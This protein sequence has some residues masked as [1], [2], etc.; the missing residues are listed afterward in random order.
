MEQIFAAEMPFDASW[1][2]RIAQGIDDPNFNHQLDAI[3]GWLKTQYNEQTLLPSG[4]PILDHAKGL[5][6]I[7]SVLELDPMTRLAGLMFAHRTPDLPQSLKTHSAFSQNNALPLI[8][9]RVAAYQR[10]VKLGVTARQAG[11]A[12]RGKASKPNTGNLHQ[13]P[14]QTDLLRRML[15]AMASDLSVVLMRLA[16]RLQTMRWYAAAKL[17]PPPELS[18]ETLALYGPLANRLGI[19]QI[20]WE[21]EDLAFRF[22]EPQAYKQLAALLEEKRAAR[23]AFVDEAIKRL[24]AALLSANLNAQVSGRPKHLYSIRN[25]MLSKGLDLNGLYDLRAFRVIVD[26][27][28][29]CYAVLSL[30][31][32]IWTPLLSEFDDYIARP[33]P[34]GYQSLHT[35]VLDADQRPFEV[36]IRTREMHVFA[37]FGVAAHWRYKE[38]AQSRAGRIA[39][40]E[41]RLGWMRQ[42]L[43]WRHE[44]QENSS[45]PDADSSIFVLTP[46]ARVIELPVGATPLDFA[47]HLHT[48]LGHLCRGARVDGHLV[49]LDTPLITGQ[50][51]EIIAAKAGGPSRDWLLR[52]GQRVYLVSSRARAKVRQW[53]KARDW[54]NAVAQGQAMVEKELARYGKTTMKMD[55]LARQAGFDDPENLFLAIAKETFTLKQLTEPWLTPVDLS[56]KPYIWNARSSHQDSVTRSGKSGVLVVGV[57]SLLTQLARCCRPV[58]PDPIVGFVTRDRGVSVHRRTCASF[59]GTARVHPERVIEVAW[60]Q[61]SSLGFYPVRIQICG[62]ERIGI[63]REI[64]EICARERINVIS[65]QEQTR[66][67]M[68]KILLSAEIA[69]AAQLS[70]S[71][72][73]LQEIEGVTE[74]DRR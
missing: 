32:E 7:L 44:V 29:D 27:T 51:V 28:D 73:L 33:K 66:H 43:A 72:L 3:T 37:E 8:M 42:L 4:E 47:Y 16:S 22:L 36:Q 11:I 31:H 18:E 24:Q 59:K 46:Q 52:S 71:L 17:S 12:K 74:V 34:N 65:V 55:A 53:F 2:L 60:G 10:L 40:D 5:C 41:A 61:S 35:V 62:Y 63:L 14:V 6:A 20:K 57:D 64:S 45:L 50:Q 39:P 19:W 21:M 67:G 13:Q 15:L 26:S 49:S 54:Q 1:R 23:E 68:T 48:D 69:D 9:E 70:R 30:L 56:E 58:P 25:K 38:G